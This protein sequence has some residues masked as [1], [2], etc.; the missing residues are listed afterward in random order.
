MICATWASR[1]ESTLTG[2]V[3]V[4]AA[5]VATGH[6]TPDVLA[7]LL[8]RLLADVRILSEDVARIEEALSGLSAPATGP[9]DAS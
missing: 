3:A 4:V 7:A 8:A 5:A 6:A 2:P 1:I 9:E